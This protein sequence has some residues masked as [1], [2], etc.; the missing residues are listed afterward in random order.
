MTAADLAMLATAFLVA[1]AFAMLSIRASHRK[2]TQDTLGQIRQS[3]QIAAS[4]L[5][6]EMHKND[7]SR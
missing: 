5:R 3:A 7:Q 2:A 6:V 4:K 1:M